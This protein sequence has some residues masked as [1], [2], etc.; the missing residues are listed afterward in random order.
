MLFAL[1]A[2]LHGLAI[3]APVVHAGVHTYDAVTI[4]G[5]DIDV[6]ATLGGALSGVTDS[7]LCPHFRATGVRAAAATTSLAV[8]NATNTGGGG[9]EPP[10]DNSDMSIDDVLDAASAFLGA[11]YSEVPPGSG[12][13][14]SADGT[15]VFRMRDSDITGR[16]GRGPHANFETLECDP[17][18]GRMRVVDNRHVYFKD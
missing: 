4:A 16:H 11:G 10:P 5:A 13:S 1:L 14:V 8:V 7:S 9:A 18:T 2:V 3:S 12:R 15:R 17:Q 6:S